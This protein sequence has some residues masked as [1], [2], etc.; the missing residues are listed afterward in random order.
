MQLNEKN[1]TPRM[2]NVAGFERRGNPPREYPKPF[3]CDECH[4]APACYGDPENPGT[5][6]VCAGCNFKAKTV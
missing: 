6:L 5:R 3:Q 2:M 1:V 4:V